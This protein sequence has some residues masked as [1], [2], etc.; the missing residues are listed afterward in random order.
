[1]NTKTILLAAIGACVLTAC[2]TSRP[3]VWTGAST[4]VRDH[5]G[6]VGVRVDYAESHDFV[7]D[8]PDTKGRATRDMAGL[9]IGSSLIA[10]GS[11]PRAALPAIMLLPAFALGG[12]VYGSVAGVSSAKLHQALDSVTNAAAACDLI[13]LLP[14]KIVSHAWSRGFDVVDASTGRTN[15][16][17]LLTMRV[18]TQQL[19]GTGSESPNPALLLHYSVQVFLTDANG[20]ALYN[21]YVET[22]SRRRDFVA[23]TANDARRLREETS[24]LQTEI[25]AKIAGRVFLGEDSE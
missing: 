12:A 24:R 9:G 16:D 10:A 5:L 22:R 3:Q 15:Y 25:A 20:R 11:D 23:W 19:I 1:M 13:V 6:T 7:F 14:E 17:T 8:Q 2:S 18:M 21:T 4:S